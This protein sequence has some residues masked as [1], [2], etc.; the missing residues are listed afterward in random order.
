LYLRHAYSAEAEISI[1]LEPLAL[2]SLPFHFSTPVPAGDDAFLCDS[3]LSFLPFI[4]EICIF[5]EALFI[6]YPK[7]KFNLSSIDCH[8]HYMPK[9]ELDQL[10]HESTPHKYPNGWHQFFY[11]DVDEEG[12]EKQK[13]PIPQES[14]CLCHFE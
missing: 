10:W 4:C 1:E 14:Y 6:S 9:N 3:L 7:K 11:G 13:F 12:K 2:G 5:I 8:H